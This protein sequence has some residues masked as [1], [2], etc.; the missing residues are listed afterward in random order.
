MPFILANTVNSVQRTDGGTVVLALDGVS[1][2]VAGDEPF[3]DLGRALGDGHHVGNLP[4]SVVAARTRTAFVV[5]VT[6]Q[7]NHL[8]A[9]LA[10]W[11][12]VDGLIDGHMRELT[13]SSAR[14]MS[15]SVPAI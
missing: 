10:A 12:G 7:R 9:Q 15:L 5:A 14:A 4:A 1:L 13:G 8:G 2:P 11:H 3:F 6:Q